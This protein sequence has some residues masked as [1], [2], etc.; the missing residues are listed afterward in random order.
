MSERY[1]T[2]AQ[3]QPECEALAESLSAHV[4]GALSPTDAS[5][6]ADHLGQCTECARTHEQLARL[7][8]ELEALVSLEPPAGLLQRVTDQLDGGGRDAAEHD[9]SLVGRALRL[10]QLALLAVY[11]ADLADRLRETG[12]CREP[13]GV[14]H[15]RVALFVA[16]VLSVFPLV[17]GW[18]QALPTVLAGLPL[19]WLATTRLE[20]RHHRGHWMLMSMLVG[21]AAPWFVELGQPAPPALALAGALVSLAV[22]Q[23]LAQP[24][25]RPRVLGL[26]R[27]SMAGRAMPVLL[28]AAAIARPDLVGATAALPLACGVAGGAVGHWVGGRRAA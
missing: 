8:A 6:V 18:Q 27:V 5:R 10:L 1:R 4:D 13:A 26:G 3:G 19:V 28:A 14:P 20:V 17:G 7:A 23:L 21:A 11:D 16:A 2:R 15:G 24:R 9:R 12:S 22:L 25:L